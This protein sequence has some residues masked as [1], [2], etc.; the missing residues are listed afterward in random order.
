M[1]AESLADPLEMPARTAKI[2][3][4]PFDAVTRALHWAT[5]L[6]VLSLF[7]S[8]WLHGFLEVRQNDDAPIV[9]WI[10]RSLGVTLWALTASRLVW[11]GTGAKLPPFPETMT[12]LHRAMVQASEYALYALLLF[13]PVTGLLASLFDGH[14][15]PLLMWDISPLPRD[16]PLRDT[17]AAMHEIGGRALGL[18]ALGHAAAGLFHHFVLRDDVLSCMAPVIAEIPRSSRARAGEP[19]EKPH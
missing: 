19:A 11:R 15:F 8:A 9:I 6:L 3:R 13:Q 14:A 2:P 18:L 10:H 5:V 12:T 7:A 17:L 1:E 4:P 16:V